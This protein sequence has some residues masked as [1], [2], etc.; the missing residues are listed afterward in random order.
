MRFTIAST[1]SSEMCTELSAMMWQTPWPMRTSTA[2]LGF[3][4]CHQ[5]SGVSS[6]Q[7]E[8]VK[9]QIPQ[10]LGTLAAEN[11]PGAVEDQFFVP[12]NGIPQPA[13]GIRFIR[14]GIFILR[15]FMGVCKKLALGNQDCARDGAVGSR[16]LAADIDQKKIHGFHF[17][18]LPG[19][20]FKTGWKN[21]FSNIFL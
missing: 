11:A 1:S 6:G 8:G 20:D 3:S 9:A 7:A 4:S 15:N 21:G 12:G 2:I 10:F 5:P 19:G 16:G 18:Q 14:N 13:K 17:G